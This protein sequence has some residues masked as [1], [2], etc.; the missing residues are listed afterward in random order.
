MLKINGQQ[1]ERLRETHG[2]DFEG[3]MVRHLRERFPLRSAAVGPPGV[4]RAV[5]KGVGSAAVNGISAER[6]VCRLVE[7]MFSLEGLDGE[8]EWVTEVLEQATPANISARIE[9]LGAL[10]AERLAR[11]ADDGPEPA[12]RDE[13]AAAL[14]G[15]RA[16]RPAPHFDG[17]AAAGDPVAPCPLDPAKKRVCSFSS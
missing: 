5:Q 9:Q 15:Q 6:D 3:K 11:P 4:L 8:R 1:M 7:L 14:A 2:S 16:R 10:A 12:L 13:A 17:Q